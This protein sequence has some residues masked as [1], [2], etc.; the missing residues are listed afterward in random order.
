MSAQNPYKAAGVIAVIYFS[1]LL[2]ISGSLGLCFV[3]I[4]DMTRNTDEA[5]LLGGLLLIATPLLGIIAS[6]FIIARGAN[7]F[8]IGVYVFFTL[9]F[10]LGAI[11]FT[12][13]VIL[14]AVGRDLN[15]AIF[16]IL[17]CMLHTC[18]FGWLTYSMWKNRRMR[19][20]KVAETFDG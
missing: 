9:L 3:I 11:G 15:G 19:P 17:I 20:E 5:M 2:L 14:N 8:S 12:L 18:L 7:K 6:A 16:A 1:I 13:A 4:A 10:A